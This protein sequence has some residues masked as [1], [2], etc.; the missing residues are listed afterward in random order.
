MNNI[1]PIFEALSYVDDRHIP[2][3]RKKSIPKKLRITLI[4]AA[5]TATVALLAGFTTAAVRGSF[6]F[7][8]SQE[9]SASHS[10][11]LNITAQEFTVPEEYRPQDGAYL[12]SAW[13]DMP[14]REMFE[15]FGI[16]PPFNDNFTDTD[17]KLFIEVGIQD[18][19]TDVFFRYAMYDK[20]IDSKVYFNSKYYSKTDNVTSK[21]H[22]ELI[23]G[24]PSEVITLND[25]SLCLVTAWRAV[26]TVN[27]AYCEIELN[28]DFDVP[29]NIGEMSEKEQRQI[30][31]EM[32]EAMPGIETV[33]QIL[34]DLA[35]IDS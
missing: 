4:A 21:M 10:F 34:K 28:Y 26:F 2:A 27:G 25:G 29:D 24:E 20:N 1:N 9:N 6:T 22:Q 16:T 13:V 30:V 11:E 3:E 35:V 15:K 32:I 5:I 19:F 17:D 7:G 31:K 33:K 8:F 23:P 12:F 14:P 18:D